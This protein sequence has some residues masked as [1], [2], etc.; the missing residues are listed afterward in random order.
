[1]KKDIFYCVILILAAAAL[2]SDFFIN[3]G[4]LLTFDG[5]IHISTIGQFSQA[6]ADGDHLVRWSDKFANYGSPLPIF[7]HQVTSYGGALLTLLTGNV[8]FSYNFLYFLG[9]ALS[10]IFFY[11]FLR[12]YVAGEAAFVGAF[13]FNFAPYRMLNIYARAALPEF[14][15]SIW[16][17]ISLLAVVAFFQKK[18]WWGAPLFILSITFLALTHPM[19]LLVNMVIIVPFFA[20][21][22]WK[23]TQKKVY[24]LIF[25]SIFLG[26]SF[27]LSA[28]YLVPLLIE[29]K[30][31][32]LGLNDSYFV[33]ESFLT[34]KNFFT[35]ELWPYFYQNQTGMRGQFF[36]LGS[37]ETVIM[38]AGM[39]YAVMRFYKTRTL[40]H[41]HLWIAVG[42]VSVLFTTKVAHILY[43]NI[44]FLGNMQFA[45]RFLSAFIFVPPVLMA[46]LLDKVPQKKL[47][48]LIIVS[49]VCMLR[50]PQIYGKNYFLY[51]QSE[52]FFTKYNLH[53]A[54]M[55]SIWTGRTEEYPVK[56]T[57]P[58]IIEGEGV[59]TDA[60]VH[61]SWRSYQISAN[62]PLRMVDNTFY[63]PGWTVEIDGVSTP[64]EFQDPVFRGIITYKIP[65]GD[66][67]VRVSFKDTKVR[68]LSTLLSLM[69][70]FGLGVITCLLY[71]PKSRKKLLQYL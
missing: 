58:E 60:Q 27:V 18:Q 16:L 15:S 56:E 57:K 8:L 40:D 67:T 28:Y 19:M 62:T 63:F 11:I 66:H 30:Y 38:L 32:Y 43:T 33:A 70:L 9:A 13:L 48:V 12:Q 51:P 31:I 4:R 2:V 46:L 7:A 55:N 3:K 47:F 36:Q 21:T 54:N 71:Y 61:N 37:I 39:V 59:I 35:L 65:Q 24:S 10:V 53:S 45:W 34:F 17:P 23:H 29:S 50:F 69:G 64:I 68:M 44:S 41:I 25:F 20:Y 22:W 1:L 5:V 52:F 49:M 6:L 14:F 42:I 26:I